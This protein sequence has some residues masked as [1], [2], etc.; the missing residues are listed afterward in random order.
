MIKF[1]SFLSLFFLS[2][3]F[4][5]NNFAFQY[6]YTDTLIVKQTENLRNESFYQVKNAKDFFYYIKD[7]NKPY[8]LVFTFTH[9]CKPCKKMHP[10]ILELEKSHKNNLQVFYLTD[11]Y[12]GNDYKNTEKYLSK[13]GNYSPIFSI[14]SNEKMKDAKGKYNY[15]IFDKR[16]NKNVKVSRYDYFIHNLI[17]DHEKFG[18]SLVILYDQNNKPIYAS[19]WEE[20]DDEVIQKVIKLMAD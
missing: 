10:K 5:Q 4:G 20:N 8:K 16:R 17:P 15:Y 11:A 18:Y 14:G 19:T 1:F 7:S 13:I 6:Y 12:N 3:F 2:F 9:W